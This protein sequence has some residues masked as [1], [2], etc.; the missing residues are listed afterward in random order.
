MICENSSS[1]ATQ[2][3]IPQCFM[4]TATTIITVHYHELES[5]TLLLCNECAKHLRK[6]ARRHGYKIRSK[7]IQ[8][9]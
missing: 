7:K 2:I 9:R 1:R 6:D 3:G 5:D 4:N 8:A